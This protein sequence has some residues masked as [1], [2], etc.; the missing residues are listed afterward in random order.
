MKKISKRLIALLLTVIMVSGTVVSA[1][2]GSDLKAAK[3]AA[4]EARN[5][6]EKY[7]KNLTSITTQR[8]ETNTKKNDAKKLV[9]SRLKTYQSAVKSAKS[10]SEFTKI[11]NAYDKVINRENELKSDIETCKQNIADIKMDLKNDKE[12]VEKAVEERREEIIDNYNDLMYWYN[13]YKQSK[14]DAEVGFQAC[15]KAISDNQALIEKYKTQLKTAQEKYDAAAVRYNEGMIGFLEWEITAYPKYADDARKA[16][17]IL[18]NGRDV[19]YIKKGDPDNAIY[20]ANVLKQEEFLNECNRLRQNDPYF[21]K[22]GE[23]LKVNN[24][25][26]AI[27]QSNANY[28]AKA[29]ATSTNVSGFW[30][31]VYSNAYPVAQLLTRLADP[32]DAWYLD[33]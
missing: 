33:K 27:A 14:E 31:C 4:I 9:N 20:L 2:A 30:G 6:V 7:E 25:A 5:S 23:I 24:V 1:D 16:L 17:D 29:S 10:S 28:S 21:N 18:T 3:N 13:D 22:K 19:K 11:Q 26:M 8:T 15:E 32:Y 12:D